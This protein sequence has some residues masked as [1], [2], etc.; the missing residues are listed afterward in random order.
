M[1]R[2][3]C[4]LIVWFCRFLSALTLR[5]TLRPQAFNASS[6][7]KTGQLYNVTPKIAA[8]RSTQLKS[9]ANPFEPTETS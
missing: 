7:P 2:C 1:A 5:H 8:A 4:H 6:R 3:H 9:E